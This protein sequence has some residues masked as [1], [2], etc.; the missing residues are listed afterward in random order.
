MRAICWPIGRSLIRL[1]AVGMVVAGVLSPNGAHRGAARAEDKPAAASPEPAGAAKGQDVDGDP[2]PAGV[3]AR[4]GT[5]RF[6]TDSLPVAMTYLAD[7]KTL[8]QITGGKWYG[9]MSYG[10]LQYRD[11][12]SGRLLREK[13]FSD[14]PPPQFACV[15]V[16]GN[17]FATSRSTLDAA[18]NWINFLEVYDLSSGTQKM[19]TIVPGRGGDRNHL[20]LSPDGKAIALG[21]RSLHVIDIAS[22]KEIA[23]KDFVGG[24]MTSLAFSPD[25]AKLAIGGPGM[26]LIWSWAAKEKPLSIAIPHDQGSSASRVAA[27]V[28]SPDGTAVA[29]GNNDHGSKGVTLYDAANGEILRSFTVPGVTRWYF[30]TVEF[31]PNGKLLAANIEDNSGNGVALWDVATGKL[32]RRLFGLFGDAYFLAFSPDSRQLAAAGAWRAAMCVWNLETFA[33]LGADLHG[34]VLP[35]NTIR[36]LPDDRRLVT[37]GDDYT[38]RL[39]NLADSRQER[40]MVHVREAGTHDSGIRGM[41]LSP[42]GKYIVSSSFDETVRLWETATGREVYRL[43]GHGHSGGHRAVR[44]TP[45]SKQ[46]ASFGDDLRVYVWDVATGKATNEFFARPAGL[47]TDP[48]PLGNPP[49]SGFGAQPTLEAACFSSDASVLYLLLDSIRRFSVRT[50]EELPKI[51]NP[52]GTAGRIAISPD[53]RYVLWNAHG[54][55]ESAAPKN[56]IDS[57]DVVKNH[58]V[59]LRSLP[60]GKLVTK[61][62]LPG[63]WDDVIE[64]SPDSS[65]VA[66]AVIADRYRIELR[67]IPDLSEVA[68]IELPSRA[69][70]V[71]FSHSGKLLATSISDSTVLI[72]DLDHLPTTKKPK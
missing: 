11:P 57:Q 49:F 3:V 27:V 48:D 36:F 10:T 72:W 50:G 56:G 39:W 6:R 17:F 64:F 70:A 44:F 18:R 61:L 62:D 25:G 5:R 66:M 55:W 38:I 7:G 13:Q 46:F 15:S 19:Q 33:P 47:K 35:P 37:A 51:E 8:L 58:P 65:L 29:V 24:E 60:D 22:Q 14:N 52:G 69:W 9:G 40:L 68:R 4:L 12:L 71:E 20:A 16:A 31:S 54:K 45:D 1:A 30:R 41:D 26:V 32:V 59:E 43:P 2:L 67:K 63:T 42:D 34:H 21:E 28:F 53:N 23:Q